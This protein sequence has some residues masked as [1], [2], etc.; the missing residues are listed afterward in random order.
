M[1]LRFREEKPVTSGTARRELGELL[2]EA[3][4]VIMGDR[5]QVGQEPADDEKSQEP[6]EDDLPIGLL[7]R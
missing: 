7:T 2:L 5:V 1:Y 4:R 6:R 3:G